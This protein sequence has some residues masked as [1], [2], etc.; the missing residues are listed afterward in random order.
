[1]RQLSIATFAKFVIRPLMLMCDRDAGIRREPVMVAVQ[2]SMQIHVAAANILRVHNP[3]WLRP[4]NRR[5]A[6]NN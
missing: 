5:T 3:R 1:M 6:T 4:V 2:P